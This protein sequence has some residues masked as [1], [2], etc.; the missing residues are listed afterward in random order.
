[1][2]ISPAEVATAFQKS[3]CAWILADAH[4]DQIL[5]RAAQEIDEFITA[6]ARRFHVTPAPFSLLE[7]NPTKAAAFFQSFTG[8]P[9]SLDIRLLIWH[10]LAGAEIVS[11][12]FTYQRQGKTTLVIET[13]TSSGEQATFT[14]QD[15]WDF[16]LFRH[17]GLLGIDERPILDG[18]YALRK[19]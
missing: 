9:H 3:G 18:Y 16:R 11:V 8:P 7:D 4:K 12:S 15:L 14:S 13:E 19:P 17:I 2:P 1:M 5:A 10:L 6:Y